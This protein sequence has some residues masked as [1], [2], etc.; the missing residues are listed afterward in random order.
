MNQLKLK[1]TVL[2]E[3]QLTKTGQDVCFKPE[4]R[5]FLLK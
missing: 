4:Q 3:L 1:A 2:V 5:K